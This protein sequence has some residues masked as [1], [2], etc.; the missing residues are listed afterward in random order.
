MEQ[1]RPERRADKVNF[2]LYSKPIL[3]FSLGTLPAEQ[4]DLISDVGAEG[5]RSLWRRE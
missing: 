3:R 1:V 5:G 2:A 4:L